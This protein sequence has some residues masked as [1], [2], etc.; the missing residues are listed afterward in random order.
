MTNS[1]ESM[2]HVK[3]EFGVLLMGAPH[4]EPGGRVL[5]EGFHVD[6]TGWYTVAEIL[7]VTRAPTGKHLTKAARWGEPPFR[8]SEKDTKVPREGRE[9]QKEPG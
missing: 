5:T 4:R 7:T 1:F 8:D 3:Y 2:S 9:G 6:F